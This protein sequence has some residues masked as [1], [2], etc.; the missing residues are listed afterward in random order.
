M[1]AARV[2]PA[3]AL[4]LLLS[5]AALAAKTDV[6]ALQGARVLTVSGAPLEGATVVLRDGLIEAVGAGVAAPPE[7]RVIDAKGLTLTPGLI[8]AFGGT[9]L[10]AAPARRPGG[11]GAASPPP[12]GAASAGLSPQASALD[13]VAVADAL[14]A[15]DS[16]VTTALVVPR[17]G[18]L[19]GRSVLLNLSGD[20]AEGM[21][22]RQPAAFHLHLATLGRQ[23]PGSLMGT[24]ALA[25]QQLWNARRYRDEWAA[26]ERAPRGRKRP[27]YDPGL[28][29]WQDVLSGTLPLMVTASRE[30]DV[31]R[32]LA[33]ADEFKVKVVVAGAPQ[34]FRS[35][36]LIKSRRLPLIVSVNF[37]PPRAAAG[38]FGGGPDEEKEKQDIEEAERNP[39]ELHRAGVV[40][41]LASAHAPSFL[42]GVQ[43]A[44]ERGLPREAA[45]R[46]VTLAAAE[47]LGVAD[48]LGSLEAGKIA[49]VVAWTAEPLTK[50][51]K[52]KMV[53]VDGQPY[54]PEERPEP[55]RG[56][57]RRPTEASR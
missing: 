51:A 22:L 47:A 28:L 20:K 21:V 37:D 36:E 39:A 10:P 18:V 40:F 46:A 38:F 34:A 17:E 54:E 26:Y 6:Y 15:R 43:K 19:P 50:E 5:H 57:G 13:R 45:L 9:G 12:G 48:R 23:Y 30:N 7:A 49:N 24:V 56:E 31:P 1:S 29:A 27:A 53:F 44:I 35:A 11:A 3:I 33:L 52:V 16:G 41:A 55:A 14:R 8:D 25:R 2:G 32:A 42:A 4:G